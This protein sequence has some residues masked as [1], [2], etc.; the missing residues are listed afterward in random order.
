MNVAYYCENI[1]IKGMNNKVKFDL[2]EN[3]II[4]DLELDGLKL[5]QNNKFF[6]FGIDAVLLSDFAKTIKRDTKV[7]DFGT[8]TGIVPILLTSKTKAKQI[9]GVEIQKELVEIAKRNVE[10]NNLQEKIEIIHEDINKLKDPLEKNTF[11][12]VVTNPPYQKVNSGVTNETQEKVIARHEVK[13][14]FETICKQ[15][16]KLLVDNGEIYIV[17][18]AER[19]ADVLFDL[20]N[21]KLEPKLLRLVYSN[22]NSKPNLILVKA[23]KNAKP[24]LKIEKNLIIYKENGEYTDEIFKI[25]GKMKEGRRW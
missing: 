7:I 13:C 9:I 15:A 17:H 3:E 23:V 11:D 19:L 6:K 4:D 8:G 21:N 12:A 1:L 16:Y 25:Y 24:F 14:D 10:L 22:P 20:R 18:R 5:I 2:K